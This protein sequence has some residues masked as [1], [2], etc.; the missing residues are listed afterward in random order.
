MYVWSDQGG[1]AYRIT[2]KGTLTVVHRFNPPGG[3]V[4]V[5]GLT[6]AKDGLYYGINAGGGLHGLGNVFKMKQGG[7]LTVLHAFD[8]SSACANP[9]SPPIQ[10]VH[11]DFYGA[12]RGDGYIY[13][14]CIYRITKSGQFTVLRSF[15]PYGL[16]G[17]LPSVPLVQGSD[18]YFY[19]TTGWNGTNNVG[20]IF[21]MSSAGEYKVLHNF[22]DGRGDY[23]SAPLI[24]AKDGNFYSVATS[25][26]THGGGVVFKITRQGAYSVLHNFGGRDGWIPTGGLVQATDGNFYGTTQSGGTAGVGVLYR[27]SPAG[28]F[29]ILHNFDGTTGTNPENTLLQHTNGILYG[30]AE[31]GGHAGK[32]TF[33]SFDLG[34]APF[35]TY[36]PTYGRAGV[37]V[38]ILGQG[39]TL[40]SQVSFNGT[41]AAS[42]VVVYPTYLKATVPA[43]AT[44]GP[45]TVT[46]DNGT[47]TS[48]KMFVVHAN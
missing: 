11:G 21:R 15:V 13:L 23:P 43:G 35:V 42:P 46:T 17:G 33:F 3:T 10:S 36:L 24:E 19:G 34:L 41:L 45:I 7:G 48:N 38:R 37:V 29:A 47:L 1:T 9:W 32:G 22:G 2:P 18:G 6:L 39:F 4:A 31:E 12:A 25:G 27:V 14:G 30:T 5:G 44:T 28:D 16:D 40:G 20:V 8:G 26:G